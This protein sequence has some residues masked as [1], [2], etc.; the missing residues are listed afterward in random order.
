MPL[1]MNDDIFHCRNNRSDS[2]AVLHNMK[3]GSYINI[4]C[5]HYKQLH[6]LRARWENVKPGYYSLFNYNLICILWPPKCEFLCI[7]FK[8]IM[9][10]FA[11]PHV[12]VGRDNAAYNK[13]Y[14]TCQ[15]NPWIVILFQIILTNH[16]IFININLE[17]RQPLYYSNC[18]DLQYV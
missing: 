17:Y 6:N 12:W 16:I 11:N 3:R 8:G 9:S 13:L 5:M 10:S 15:V 7:R 1:W 4:T 18:P 2:L 14:T